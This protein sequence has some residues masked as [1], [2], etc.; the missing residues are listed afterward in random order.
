LTLSPY[1]TEDLLDTYL[2]EVPR[3]ARF[4]GRTAPFNLTRA[5]DLLH[6]EPVHL[7]HIEERTLS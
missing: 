1:P 4:P 3:R 5:T 6:F 7:W 2:P